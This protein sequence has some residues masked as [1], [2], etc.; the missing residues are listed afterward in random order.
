[1]LVLTKRQGESLRIGDDNKITVLNIDE[2]SVELGVND[3]SRFWCQTFLYIFRII[4]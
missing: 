4:I 3:S 1:M 2:N